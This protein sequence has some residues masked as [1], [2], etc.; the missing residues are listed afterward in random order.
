[1]RFKLLFFGKKRSK[2]ELELI[3]FILTRFGYRPLNLSFFDQALTHKSLLSNSEEASN[4]R[5]EFL[6]D[7]ILDVVVA[8]YLYQRYPTEDEGFL[9]KIKSKIVNRKSLAEIAEKMDLR[10]IIRFHKGRSIN[11]STVEGNAFEA[12][13]GAIYLD[14]GYDAVKKSVQHHVFRHFLD[15]NRVLDEEIDF[16]SKLFIW[17]QKKRL[18]LNFVVVSEENSGNNWEYTIRVLINNSEYGLGN[19]SSKKTAEQDA[20]KKTLE[21]LNEN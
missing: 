19:G 21:L 2:N 17:C 3:R 6:G 8:E 7:A 20:S 5:L 15:L 14:G 11:I 12:I 10:K 16:K 4:E 18:E 1:L 13:I 9:T